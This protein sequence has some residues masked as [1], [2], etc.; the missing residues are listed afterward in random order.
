MKEYFGG[1][2]E[3]PLRFWVMAQRKRHVLTGRALHGRIAHARREVHE[4]LLSNYNGNP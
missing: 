2:R 3:S 1:Q 4:N